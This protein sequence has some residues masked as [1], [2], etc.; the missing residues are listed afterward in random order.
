MNISRRQFFARMRKLGFS[1]SRFQLTRVGVTYE[2]EDDGERVS[3]TVPKN[4]SNTFQILGN[5]PYSGIF[6]RCSEE[7]RPNWGVH[8]PEDMDPLQACLDICSGAIV[9]PSK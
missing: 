1:K 2:R 8:I 7:S 6:V 3:V 9:P 4:H 5:V